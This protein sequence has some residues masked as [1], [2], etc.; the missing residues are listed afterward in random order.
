MADRYNGVWELFGAGGT[1]PA[2]FF[3]PYARV[4]SVEA[5][6]G[7]D[8]LTVRYDDGSSIAYLGTGLALS[9]QLLT[10]TITGLEVRDSGGQLAARMSSTA[11]NP[12]VL[13][14]GAAIFGG[15]AFLDQLL[16]GDNLIVG[17]GLGTAAAR[18]V[19]KGSLGADTYRP[20]NA[21][22]AIVDGIGPSTLDLSGLA[23]PSTVQLADQT[24]TVGG[25]TGSMSGVVTVIGTGGDDTIFGTN[26]A[27]FSLSTGAGNDVVYA[28]DYNLTEFY[29]GQFVVDLGEGDD[30]V[31]ANQFG[32]G[33]LRGGPGADTVRATGDIRFYR[34]EGIETLATFAPRV[35][36]DQL[37][38]FERITNL[39]GLSGDRVTFELMTDGTVD[40]GR[41]MAPGLSVN[42]IAYAAGTNV[43][44]TAGD[45][46]FQ[47]ESPA[48]AN[49]FLT[50]STFYGGGGNDTLLNNSGAG[51]FIFSG[52]LADYTI[53]KVP[54]LAQIWEI[55]D[56]RPGAPDGVD[57]I[58]GISSSAPVLRFA[59]YQASIDEQIAYKADPSQL[60]ATIL[61]GQLELFG[62]D[63]FDY[64]GMFPALDL[65]RSQQL[66]PAGAIY[67][68][69]YA[70]GLRVDF[71]GTGLTTSGAYAPS[72]G[73][74]DEILLS[75][76]TAPGS[77]TPLARFSSD[78]AS[79]HRFRVPF[80]RALLS[81][82]AK[83]YQWLM[84]GNNRV[85]GSP[86]D[87]VIAA[88]VGRNTFT[89]VPGGS[90]NSLF[91]GRK[92]DSFDVVR[93]AAGEILQVRYVD[94]PADTYNFV[95]GLGDPSGGIASGVLGSLG[96]VAGRPYDPNHPN[97]VPPFIQGILNA[98]A[99]GDPH[100]TTMDGV[101][102]S[103]QA[104]GE[105]V[106][107]RSTIPGDS[108][109]IQAR[110]IPFLGFA[111]LVGQAAVRVG[112]DRVS[113]DPNRPDVVRVNGLAVDFSAGP[114]QLDGAVL[115]QSGTASW[116][117][118]RDGGETLS[119]S[120]IFASPV[121]LSLSF[122][123]GSQRPPG[124]LVGLWGNADHNRFND[125]Q[126]ADGTV[127][128]RPLGRSTL[129]GPFADAWRVSQATSLLDYGAGESTGTYTRLAPPPE[130]SVTDLPREVLERAEAVASAAGITD[131]TLRAF[132][133]YD[134]V[135]TGD[136]AAV[137]AIASAQQSGLR[138]GDW[139]QPA[140]TLTAPVLGVIAQTPQVTE[141]ASGPTL[142]GFE[143]F[144]T[145]PAVAPAVVNWAVVAPGA[146]YFDA[147][148][149]PGG[150]LP[151]GQVTIPQ[152]QNVSAFTVA[153]PEG[154]VTQAGELLRVEISSPAG[155]AVAAA[156]AQVEVLN[157]GPASA[158][159][160]DA[161]FL[162]L[163]GP[164]ALSHVGD[165]WTL[166]LG[167]I[168]Q[169]SSLDP[170]QLALVNAGP[171]RGNLL[172]G[173]FQ[174]NGS[175]ASFAGLAPVLRLAGGGTQGG[176]QASIDTG[177]PGVQEAALTFEARQSNGTGF[178]APLGTETLTIRA[179][180]Q[181][182]VVRVD[183]G[184]AAFTISGTPAV[185]QTLTADRTADDPDGNG[186]FSYQWQSSANGASWTP[187]G[188]NAGTYA[189]TGAEEGRQVRVVVSYTDGEG[190]AESVQT[191][192]V[193]VP[194]VDDGDAAFRISGTPA[195]GQTL[196]ADRTADDPDGNGVFSYQ[197]Q[198]SADGSSWDP[199]GSDASAYQ[200]READQGRQVRV[201]ISY[202]DAEGFPER[203]LAP[204]VRVPPAPTYTV[205][206][207]STDLV[208]GDTVTATLAT[209]D[210]PAGTR[211]WWAF[212]GP[213]IT[214]GD[215]QGGALTGDG[216]IGT[217][218]RFVVSG[219]IARDALI[220]PP[221]TLQLRFFADSGRSRQVGTTAS[222][223]IREPLVG[224]PTDGSDTITGTAAAD[225]LRGVPLGSPTGQRGRGTIDRLTGLGEG[226]LFVLGDE[227]GTFY[228]DGN[229]LSQGR[230]DFGVI[231][232]F[233]AG[234][235][236]QLHG[237]PQNYLLGNGT[238][239]GR[240][241]IFIYARNPDRPLSS[242]VSFYDEAIGFV[243][244]GRLDQLNLANSGQ[245][246]YATPPPG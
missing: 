206:P 167:P 97:L 77:P 71:K 240:F 188:I 233:G 184:D 195:V 63:N 112:T 25:V 37:R 31:V 225:I 106:L 89:D 180:I 130:F 23:G 172:S 50:A 81:G 48:V 22:T 44:G 178:T 13:T 212:S 232:D 239:E 129:Y 228:D 139:E 140:T 34:F 176:I 20:G 174:T 142:V 46:V 107:T 151:S 93:N 221:E 163:S 160:A 126:L 45:D 149:F 2:A 17:S 69:T 159:P 8:R 145:G 76:T 242:R 218:G 226:D 32:Y 125:F 55:A 5:T 185:G 166:D 62:P 47:D 64:E 11:A 201:Q 66:D 9:G 179:T 199:V 202:T 157:N 137:T 217:D 123:P 80:S 173:V 54:S 245:F 108:F 219:S 86:N 73:V 203:V 78:P 192:P 10:G 243:E 198:T 236:I 30:T 210:V 193:A 214:A 24:F 127:L 229:P 120:Q 72:G 189:L 33:L 187:I 169:G 124:T 40:F 85:I 29:G 103:F 128:Q 74:V 18:E 209:T 155:L 191:T 186:V 65:A 21:Y 111:S 60:P 58:V 117:L 165:A 118:R 43:I 197:W 98:L 200:V 227:I 238:F 143:A 164:G 154:V 15:A 12:F 138:S 84:S 35:N 220:E 57:R 27:L 114:L 223:T 146:G 87:D 95:N 216:T 190:F 19:L 134:Y 182:A 104:V 96:D 171:T 183:D 222:Y 161:A 61:N 41:R 133:V 28:Y 49:G 79:G 156:A 205:T 177:T 16:S 6:P 59:D 148:D 52:N 53:T 99:G 4:L 92:V 119:I 14:G 141:A 90:V 213:G 150:A 51:V 38:S 181:P 211:F 136:V 91:L 170:V 158:A 144:R 194:F 88:D 116:T 75:D 175:L 115:S 162:K 36:T 1:D 105:F 67:S 82:G 132:A 235:R 94:D 121:W 102:Y 244:G 3:L 147:A 70:N 113:F 100:L 241:G 68:V 168:T 204:A 152:G 135:L 39:S 246:L 224:N 56:N 153:L 131:Q 110:F 215:L 109:E 237:S 42:A 196:T 101:G 83:L 207:G 231:T 208:E 7:G 230:G 26:G 234:D 122:E